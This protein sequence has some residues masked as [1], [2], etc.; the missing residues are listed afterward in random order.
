VWLEE[1]VKPDLLPGE[2][3]VWTGRP[4]AGHLLTYGDALLIPFSLLWGG[5]AIFWEAT[6]L[7]LTLGRFAPS[8]FALF[9]VPF[10]LVGLYFI[11]GRFIYKAWAKGRTI[12]AVTDRRVMVVST[13]FG[14]R[15]ESLM[16]NNLPGLGT[17]VG[18]GGVGSITFGSGG[19]ASS[20]YA[21][22]G[23][24][25]P[26]RGSAAMPMAFYDVENVAS[27][28]A[29]IGDQQKAARVLS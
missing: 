9:G 27:V 20:L 5:F 17:S 8:F 11:A 19:L 12:Y 22:S 18:S 29:L 1:Q 21:N 16:L 25:F 23:M 14:R 10:V 3:V 26:G 13:T 15:S 6:A 2:R 24:W 7:G 28:V 4:A